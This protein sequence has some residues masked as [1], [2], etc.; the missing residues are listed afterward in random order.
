ML[1]DFPVLSDLTWMMT[2]PVPT[3]DNRVFSWITPVESPGRR[4]RVIAWVGS[5]SSPTRLAVMGPLVPAITAWYSS[6]V[7][8]VLLTVTR[9]VVAPGLGNVRVAGLSWDVKPLVVGIMRPDVASPCTAG[10]AVEV[11]IA[12]RFKEPDS[13]KLTASVAM[14][15]D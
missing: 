12:V 9:D 1:I 7:L 4:N 8:P 5:P 10:L 6:W 15:T 3:A 2:M 13:A 14:A 11:A